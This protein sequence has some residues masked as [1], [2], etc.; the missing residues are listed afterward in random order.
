MQVLA[1]LRKKKEEEKQPP[2]QEIKITTP[3]R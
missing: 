2:D 3:D 1:D